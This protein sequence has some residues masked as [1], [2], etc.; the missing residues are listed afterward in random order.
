MLLTPS[1]PPPQKQYYIVFIYL[2]GLQLCNN[3]YLTHMTAISTMAEGKSAAPEGANDRPNYRQTYTDK[4]LQKINA[5]IPICWFH[6][7]L[8]A[9]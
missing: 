4:P 3:E 8:H 2:I 9:F 5:Y 6:S 7:F 1:R